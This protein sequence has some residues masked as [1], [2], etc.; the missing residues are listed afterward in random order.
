MTLTQ[1]ADL[2]KSLGCTQALNLDGGAS[3]TMFVRTTSE[4]QEPGALP[5][6]KTVCGRTPETQVKSVLLLQPTAKP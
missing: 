2:L 5:A 1:L 3:S 4:G 6:G